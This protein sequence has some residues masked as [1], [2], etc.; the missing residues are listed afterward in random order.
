MTV[1]K[2]TPYHAVLLPVQQQC[3]CRYSCQV[4]TVSHPIACRVQS[5]GNV[6][7]IGVHNH[8]VT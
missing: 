2:E 4:P 3:S 7:V 6:S 1:I 8:T 5:I